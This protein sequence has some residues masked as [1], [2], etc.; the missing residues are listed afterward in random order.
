MTFGILSYTFLIFLAVT[1]FIYYLVPLKFRWF[2]LFTASCAFFYFSSGLKMVPYILFGIVITFSGANIIAKCQ[3]SVLKKIVLILTLVF[4]LGELFILKDLNFF[5]ILERLFHKTNRDFFHFTAP[6]GISYYMLSSIGY[7]L[8]I[9]WDTVKPQKNILKHTLFMIY[10]PQMT[11]GPFTTYQTISSQL[12]N[13]NCYNHDRITAGMQRMIWGFF[14]KLVI[15]DR[16]ALLVNTVYANPDTYSGFYI[17]TAILFFTIQLYA[18]FS[19]CMDIILGTSE[20]FGI[21]LPEN[22]NIP[23][24]SQNISEFWRRW[25]ISLGLWFKS[26]LFYPVLKSNCIQQIGN[27]FKSVFSKKTAKNITVYI[28]LFIDWFAI[29]LWHGG[30]IKFIIAS[31]MIPCFV[32]I[33]SILFNPLLKKVISVFH[34]KTDCFSYRFF[35]RIRTFFIIWFIFGIIRSESFLA[36]IHLYKKLFT[37]NPWILFDGSLLKLGIDTSNM[38]LLC[39]SIFILLIVDILHALNI[40]LRQSLRAQNILFQW[41]IILAGLFYVIIFGMYGPSYSAADFIYKGF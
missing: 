39:V 16:A 38:I 4:S 14:K 24:M 15:A 11:S 8:D 18:D 33:F 7:V 19:G 13:G 30:T 25:H 36:A 9:Y 37:Y 5:L 2:I 41:V 32:I 29:G 3:N 21:Y 27:K 17:V 26:Y 35:G 34:I 28:A 1:L 20:C 10:F 12:F 6:L 31:G 22:F 40:K 23:F